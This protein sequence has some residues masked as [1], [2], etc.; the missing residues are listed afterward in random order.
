MNFSQTP[1]KKE[2]K[3]N[4]YGQLRKKESSCLSCS[5]VEDAEVMALALGICPVY[6]L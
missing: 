2:I 6:K 3:A 1:A 5:Q 4:C